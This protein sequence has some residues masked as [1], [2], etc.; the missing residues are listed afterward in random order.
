MNPLVPYPLPGTQLVH[1]GRQPIFDVTGD[2]VAY[3][4]L[5]R[6]SM[7]AVEAGRRDTYATS[8]V[9]V[10]TFTEFGIDEV[11]GDR[12]CFIN[13]TREFLT[14]E[15]TLPFGPEHVVLEVLETVDVDD[16]VVDGVT[17]LA[18]KGYRIA[19]DDFV[20]GSGHERLLPLAD[21]VKLDLL[22]AEPDHLDAI[23]AACREYP[24]IKIVAEGLETGEQLALSN[25]YGFELR[26]GYV[27]SRPQVL[28]AASLT[29][30]K[31]R[32]LELIGALSASDADLEQVLSIIARDPALT[33]RVLRAS[34]SVAAGATSRVSSVRQA[35]VMLG[36]AHIRQWAMLMVVDD[37]AEATEVQMA[38]AL[39]RAR[40]CEHVAPAFGADPDAAFMAGLI[41]AVA[42]MI[43]MTP[44]AIAHQLPLSTDITKALERGTGSLGQVLRVVDAYER[45]DLSAVAAAYSGDD[46]SGTVMAAMRWSTMAVAATQNAA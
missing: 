8:Q 23:V 9:I 15:L 29:P 22:A 40:L 44:A 31:L 24:K 13:M 3:E 19:L 1:V 12:T 36:L 26:Q 37:V 32:R 27:L 2:V 4:L 25:R 11:V 17:A 21:F 20:W 41:T 28:T 14:G 35:V 5:F 34:N 43:G 7:D 10:N 46:L 45:G 42:Q 33:L 6:G 16:E 39:T 38:D 30:S 18:A